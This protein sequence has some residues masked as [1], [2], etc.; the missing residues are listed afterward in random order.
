M[1]GTT[2]LDALKSWLT[3]STA[4]FKFI[5]SSVPF[6]NF[7]DTLTDTWKAFATERNALFAFVRDNE[8]PGVVLISGDQHWTGIFRMDEAAPYNFYEF[9]PTPLGTRNQPAPGLNSEVLYA[10]NQFVGHGRF[11]A[12]TAETPPRLKFEW[13]DTAGDV[14]MTYTITTTDIMP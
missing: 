8:I 1:L 11:T 7:A 3:T 12:Y 14:Q 2:Q 10:N 4:T 9:M 13:V 6:T 5:V